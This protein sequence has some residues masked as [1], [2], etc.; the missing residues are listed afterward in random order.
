MSKFVRAVSLRI[1]GFLVVLGGF[2]IFASASYACPYGQRDRCGHVTLIRVIASLV[3]RLRPRRMLLGLPLAR[4]QRA[5]SAPDPKEDRWAAFRNDGAMHGLK[6]MR[7][8]VASNASAAA[9]A[10]T[11][12]EAI[13]SQCLPHFGDPFSQRPWID[14][15]DDMPIQSW[16]ILHCRIAGPT[17][18]VTNRGPL[19]QGS[20][21]EGATAVA[22]PMV[23][24]ENGLARYL[25][26]IRRFPMLEPQEEYMLAFLLVAR[27]DR[28]DSE[29]N[30]A[31]EEPDSALDE[32]DMRP[33]QVKKIAHRLGVTEQDVID[34]S[35]RMAR[36]A[37]LNSPVRGSDPAIA[38]KD[39]FPMRPRFQ[40]SSMKRRM[41]L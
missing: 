25:N 36:D 37:S 16:R 28:N 26:Q 32:G 30:A 3:S 5:T 24:D 22:L 11:S 21:G 13:S 4:N 39:W 17:C 31:R 6:S 14:G 27:E 35:R 8:R 19:T 40:L 33:D 9:L 10:L 2:L 7:R 41:E 20:R 23:S 15:W 12:R 29:P 38:S 1:G 18:D 34:M